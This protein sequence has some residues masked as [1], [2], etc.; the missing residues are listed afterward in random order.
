VS[1]DGQRLRSVGVFDGEDLLRRVVEGLFPGDLAEL[2]FATLAD[3]GGV[4]AVL[5]DIVGPEVVIT[6]DVE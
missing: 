4:I 2:A 5:V 3:I 1:E 6:L